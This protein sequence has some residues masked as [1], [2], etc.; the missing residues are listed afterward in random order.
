V[1]D[2][3]SMRVV[4]EQ[5]KGRFGCVNGVIHAA[6]VPGAGLIELKS[7]GAA[8]KVLAPKVR[9]TQVLQAVLK[10]EELDFLC[11]C[12]S[13]ATA[14]EGVGQVDYFAANAYLDA[15]ALHMRGRSSTRTFALSWDAWKEVGMAVQTVVPASLRKDREANLKTGISPDEGREFF[16][17]ALASNLSHVFVSTRDLPQRI[18]IIAGEVAQTAALPVESG[19]SEVAAA[20]P[21]S[22]AH[23]RPELICEYAA[24]EGET[25]KTI[26]EIWADLLGI[27][28]VGRNDDVFELG[29]N[30][31]LLMQLSVRLRT[32][33]GVKLPMRTLF[34]TPTVV[35][36]AERVESV[37]LVMGAPS[38]GDS[39]E[40]TDEETEEVSL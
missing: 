30:S 19:G 16:R 21:T 25:E 14:I 27:D 31:L 15:F 22:G 35:S 29:G 8:R 36:L 7:R 1:A 20:A 24:P 5:A 32:L 10:T 37:G 12:S 2:L 6:G 18:A 9:G 39:D 33:Y 13:L 28:R 34:E 3:E 4:V 40:E 23:A 17:R 11:L 26:A 38:L